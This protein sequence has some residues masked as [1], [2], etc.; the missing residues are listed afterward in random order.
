MP[1]S[2][3]MTLIEFLTAVYIPPR[4]GLSQSS[5][6]QIEIAVR[7]FSRWLDRPATLADL[8]TSS[9]CNW[10]RWLAETRSP[11]TVNSKRQP[12]LSLWRAACEE[13]LCEPPRKWPPRWPEPKRIPNAWTIE[14][15]SRLLDATNNIAVSSV[16]W[17]GCPAALAWRTAILLIWD[18]G[19]R[20]ATLLDA[21]VSELD[22][23]SATWRVPAEH[24]KGKR[25]DRVYRL[26]PDTVAILRTSLKKPRERIFPFPFCKHQVWPHL[27]R[28]LRTAGL[29]CDRKHLF[30]CLRRTTESYAAAARGVE[31]AAA[32]VGHSVQV[33]KI[34]YICPAIAP[35]PS[36]IDAVPRPR[37]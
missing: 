17:D 24:C 1:S 14:Q 33:A 35:G 23:D 25:A 3:L 21:S 9:I 19:C 7:L 6:Q 26:H 10:M 29:P 12:I 13:G 15:V 27:K 4:L 32:A 22:L 8:S 20:L 30:H 2:G 11:A 16:L 31:W 37:I 18:T 34:S 5:A 28:I 36:L